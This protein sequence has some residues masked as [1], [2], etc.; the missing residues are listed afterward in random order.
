MNIQVVNEGPPAV[1]VA[2]DLPIF[3]VAVVVYP[4]GRQFVPADGYL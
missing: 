3:L 2:P 4:N 1:D